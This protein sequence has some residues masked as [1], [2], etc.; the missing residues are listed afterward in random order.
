M[1]SPDK[2]HDLRGEAHKDI[3]TINELLD[4]ARRISTLASYDEVEDRI[5]SLNELADYAIGDYITIDAEAHIQALPNSASYLDSREKLS[6]GFIGF[7]YIYD[8]IFEDIEPASRITLGLNRGT[9]SFS[10]D[11]TN[12]I[13]SLN[14]YVPVN[15]A[16]DLVSLPEI[17][18]LLVNSQMNDDTKIHKKLLSMME[19]TRKIVG[20]KPL[21]GDYTKLSMIEPWDFRDPVVPIYD[22]RRHSIAVKASRARVFFTDKEDYQPFYV[23]AKELSFSGFYWATSSLQWQRKSP[24]PCFV[25]ELYSTDNEYLL[26]FENDDP[27]GQKPLVYVPIS[28]QVKIDI[29]PAE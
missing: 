25:F 22:I 3:P 15:Q 21:Y 1:H 10:N 29:S 8:E 6:G 13:F 2:L 26:N 24:K 27:T 17:G 28:D 7:H 11:L 5:E 23:D 9:A 16:S 19:R 4:H 18:R 14:A 12:G 20:S